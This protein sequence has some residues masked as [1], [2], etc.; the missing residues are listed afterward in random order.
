LTKKMLSWRN[1]LTIP[2]QTTSFK[3]AREKTADTSRMRKESNMSLCV[4]IHEEA[5][6]VEPSVGWSMPPSVALA[7]KK[8]AK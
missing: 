7:Q 2:S 5:N 4:Q 1:A 3:V 8:E 6:V